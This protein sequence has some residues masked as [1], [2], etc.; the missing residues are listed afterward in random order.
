MENSDNICRHVPISA[1][2]TQDEN[3]HYYMD[4]ERSEFAD[5]PGDVFAQ[6]LIQ[7]FGMDAILKGDGVKQKDD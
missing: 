4:E 3:G 2:Y 6:F 5:I 7:K 1:Y